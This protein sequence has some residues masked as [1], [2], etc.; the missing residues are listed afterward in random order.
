VKTG[1]DLTANYDFVDVDSLDTESGSEIRWFK[2]NILQ[3]DLNDT[4]TVSSSLT[5]KGELWYFTIEPRDGSD[6][7]T[8]R[9]SA[10]VTILNTAPI[11]NNLSLT[12]STP[13]TTD[14]LQANYNWTDTDVGDLELGSE[15]LW[16]RD[17]QLIG[18]LNDS[19]LVG[20]S[21][22]AKGQNWHFKIRPADGI[23][24]GVWVSCPTNLT[25]GN[26][27]PEAS[28]VQITPSDARTGNE[29]TALYNWFDND[30]TD[31]DNDSLPINLLSPQPPL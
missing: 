14:L 29:L 23:N 26:T 8:K 25:I 21:Y 22:T 16:Y 27:A 4:T 31:T 12:P 11:V 6:F 19:S 15:I 5:T 18:E 7:G 10:A 28:N 24:L 17:N 20:P 13:V 2:N 1:N 9:T 30:T 3:V